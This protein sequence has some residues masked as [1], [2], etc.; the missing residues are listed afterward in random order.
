M[1]DNNL[2]QVSKFIKDKLSQYQNETNVKLD[3]EFF[4]TAIL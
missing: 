3:N 2:G 1:F 4:K